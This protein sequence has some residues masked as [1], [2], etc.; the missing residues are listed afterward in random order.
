MYKHENG[1]MVKLKKSFHK[2]FIPNSLRNKLIDEFHKKFSHIDGIKMLT[3]IS[4]CY[5]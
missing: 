5:Y 2:I 3:M 1:L 4:T